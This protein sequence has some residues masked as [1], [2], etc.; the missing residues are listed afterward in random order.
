MSKRA[1]K[2]LLVARL[3]R[4]TAAAQLVATGDHPPGDASPEEIEAYHEAEQFAGR[5]SAA[6]YN[7]KAR[8]AALRR[9]ARLKVKPI[10]E[11]KRDRRWANLVIIK[12][13]VPRGQQE[14]P[15]GDPKRNALAAKWRAERAADPVRQFAL[16]SYYYEHPDRKPTTGDKK[17]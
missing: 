12:G 5:K 11:R 15:R 8:Q 16:E 10:R 14:T 9:F 17:P 4:F 6:R 7:E 2:K 1:R 3:E 13:H